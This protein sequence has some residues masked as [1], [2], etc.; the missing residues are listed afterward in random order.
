VGPI[1]QIK[2]KKYLL[3]WAHPFRLNINIFSQLGP[4]IQ[5][6]HKYLQPYE[7]IHSHWT[8]K[9]SSQWAYSFI[10]NINIFSFVDPF[11]HIEQQNIY[12]CGLTH[13]H[14]TK[15]SSAIW[16]HSFTLVNKI[17][18]QMGPPIYIKHKIIQPSQPTHP[19]YTKNVCL[20]GPSH[21]DRTNKHLFKW[22]HLFRL[23]INIFSQVGPF[24]LI[25]SKHFHPSG[26]IL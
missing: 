11:I 3:K 16:A 4:F 23:N 8:T 26:P 13:S 19:N 25:E 10:L 20:S 12:P 18:G 22:A 1:I 14:W 24:I 6:V 5:I 2:Q 21:S 9:Y 17:L 15:I 7:P